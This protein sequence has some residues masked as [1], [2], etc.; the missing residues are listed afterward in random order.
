MNDRTTKRHSL[1]EKAAKLRAGGATWATIATAVKRSAAVVQRWPKEQADDWRLAY[2]TAKKDLEVETENELLYVLRS[3]LRSRDEK[4]RCS[5]A[6]MFLQ[7]HGEN[8]RNA[9]KAIQI[10]ADEPAPGQ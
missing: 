1:L 7:L 9:L 8:E 2:E 10:G 6:A 3:L 4:I 5:A